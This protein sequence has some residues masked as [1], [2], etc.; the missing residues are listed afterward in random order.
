M[1][2][3]EGEQQ[4]GPEPARNGVKIDRRS[5]L[6]AAAALI[7]GAALARDFGAHGAPVRYPDPDVV[8]ST[9]ASR[10][11]SSATRPSS[12]STPGCSGP[13]GRPGTASAGIWS[14]ATSRTTCRCAGS[15]RTATSA[16]FRNPSGNSNGNTFDYEGRQLS[17]EH[18]S[19]RVV[20]YE[21]DGTVTVLADKFK[22]KRLNSPNDVVV[23]PD[24]G[25]WFTDPGYGILRQLRGLQGGRWRSRKRSTASTRRPARS[26]RSP[27]SCQAERPLLLARLQEALHRRHRCATTRGAKN[28]KV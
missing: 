15:R 18:G 14:G 11:T 19:R 26:R 6:A 21:H 9:S 1:K 7:P 24:G 27:T 16:S 20:R 4:G 22:G 5:L 25:I 17:C 12:A 10:S 23:H 3:V 28:I 8:A 2:R 13:K